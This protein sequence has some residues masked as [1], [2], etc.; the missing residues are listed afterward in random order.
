MA[1]ARRSLTKIVVERTPPNPSQDIFLWDGRI[2][3]FG[4]R[5]SPSG[6]QSYIFQYRTNSRQQRRVVLG[7]HGPLTT[8]A[9]RDMAADLYE[10]VR[11]GRDPA[12][13]MRLAAAAGSEHA[14]ERV[15]PQFVEMHLKQQRRAA[16]YISNTET[17][18]RLHVL[19]HW[20]GKDRLS[21]R[22]SGTLILTADIGSCSP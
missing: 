6:R 20:S 14:F 10:G 8:E 21:Y 16:K 4:V 15:V 2:P 7:V 9:A 19:P 3:G 13:E 22:L 11:R 12:N 18:F 5:V 17:I 1:K